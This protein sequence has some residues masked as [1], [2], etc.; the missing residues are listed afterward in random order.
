MNTYITKEGDT[1]DYIAWK[2]YGNQNPGTTEAL[3]NANRGLA[4]IGPELP[5]GISIVL[6]EISLPATTKGVKLWD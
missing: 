1:A 3:I 5:S 6:P 4:D 2:V